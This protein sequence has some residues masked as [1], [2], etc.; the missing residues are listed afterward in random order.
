MWYHICFFVKWTRVDLSKE[1]SWCSIDCGNGCV[2]Q[3]VTYEGHRFPLEIG[4]V[5]HAE[6]Q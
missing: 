3:H 4:W 2:R 1:L 6:E 5:G